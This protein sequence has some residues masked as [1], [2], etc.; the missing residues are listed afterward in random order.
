MAASHFV[1]VI[2]TISYAPLLQIKVSDGWYCL[3]YNI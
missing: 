2:A 3:N 1:G